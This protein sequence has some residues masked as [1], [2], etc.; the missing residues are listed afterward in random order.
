MKAA[1]IVH[2]VSG[3]TFLLGRKIHE[4]LLEKGISASFY[5]VPDEDAQDLTFLFPHIATTLPLIE[6]LPL[7]SPEILL[8]S[9]LIFLG[10]PTYFGNM[11]GEMKSFLD[12]TGIYWPEAKLRG[13]RMLAFTTAGTSE[14]GAHLCLQSLTTYGLHMGMFPLPVP[15][16]LSLPKVMPSYGIVAYSGGASDIPPEESVLE[17]VEQIIAWITEKHL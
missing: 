3:N 14:G 7:A 9:D 15:M 17:S 5:R 1:V 2:S 16:H 8:E 10:S 11:S 12:S 4:T 6:K 13:K